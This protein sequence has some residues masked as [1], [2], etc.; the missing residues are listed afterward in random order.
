MMAQAMYKCRMCYTFVKIDISNPEKYMVAHIEND[1]LHS[2]HRCPDDASL[3]I[4]F[5]ILDL[6]GVIEL[7]GTYEQGQAA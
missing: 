2:S 1:L 5:G 3:P 7:R 4:R 6:I